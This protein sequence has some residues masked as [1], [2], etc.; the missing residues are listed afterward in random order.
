MDGER[1]ELYEPSQC[2]DHAAVIQQY[3]LTEAEQRDMVL[4]VVTRIAVRHI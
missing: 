4:A 2:V 1:V 3:E